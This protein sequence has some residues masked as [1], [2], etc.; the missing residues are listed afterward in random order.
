MGGNIRAESEYGKGSCFRFVIPIGETRTQKRTPDILHGVL[1]DGRRLVL[2]IDDEYEAQKIL[3]TYLENEGYEVIQAYNGMEAIQ[4]A[5]KFRP[6]A[7]TLDIMMP[8]KDG[9]DILHA[10]KKD[11][12]TEA[13]PVICI[14]ILDNRELGLS[15]G[16]VEYL[17][18]PI[19]KG[20]LMEELK[21]LERRFGIYGHPDRG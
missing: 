16:A 14:S 12:M 13:I 20:Q 18:K 10:L 21:R 3:K 19:D 17:V 11:P 2:T 1:D 7:I 4:L 15:L 8:G 6:F 5:G 9:W